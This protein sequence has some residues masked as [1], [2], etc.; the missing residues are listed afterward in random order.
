MRIR[1]KKRLRASIT[2]EV[3]SIKLHEVH[4]KQRCRFGQAFACGHCDTAL[5]NHKTE[6]TKIFIKYT[7]FWICRSADFGGFQRATAIA[8][9]PGA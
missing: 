9:G 3:G 4:T 6:P 1:R 7:C 2:E 8:L 5:R